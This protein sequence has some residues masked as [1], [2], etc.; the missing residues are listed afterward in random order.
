[1]NVE[2]DAR[3]SFL[4]QDTMSNRGRGSSFRSAQD[5]HVPR[6]EIDQFYRTVGGTIVIQVIEHERQARNNVNN[7]NNGPQEE[8]L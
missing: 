8:S 2:S 4:P 7:G 5:D 6:V 1:M 3:F